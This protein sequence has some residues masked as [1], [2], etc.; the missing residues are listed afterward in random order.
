MTTV[1]LL[2]PDSLHRGKGRKIQPGQKIHASVAFSP[3]EYRPKAVL[4]KRESPPSWK[5]LIQLNGDT[6]FKYPKDWEVWLD[7]DIFDPTAAQTV[8]SNLESETVNILTSVHRLTVMTQSGTS[9]TWSEM[10]WVSATD[11]RNS[12]GGC[13]ALRGVANAAKRVFSV[14]QRDKIKGEVERQVE[15][16]NALIMFA[17]DIPG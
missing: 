17:T 9:F 7:M 2:E 6:Q 8:I 4:P 10:A 15:I 13:S 11:I 12:D 3:S 1:H 14:L 5:G 16:L